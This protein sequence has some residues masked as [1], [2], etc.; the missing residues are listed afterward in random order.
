MLSLCQVLRIYYEQSKDGPWLLEAYSLTGKIDI[1][2]IIIQM[3]NYKVGLL[4]IKSI[5]YVFISLGPAMWMLFLLL[6]Q[7]IYT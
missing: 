5:V 3:F 7:L 1:N 6:I 4:E 2:Q